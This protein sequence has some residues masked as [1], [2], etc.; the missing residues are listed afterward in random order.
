MNINCPHLDVG[1]MTTW[2]SGPA[3]RYCHECGR[4]DTPSDNLIAAAYGVA[5]AVWAPTD[6]K[7]WELVAILRD[8]LDACESL[9]MQATA[10]ELLKRL[11]ARELEEGNE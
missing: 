1:I 6:V 7:F 8:A 4:L 3:Y 10:G 9:D 2:D 5:N 11:N